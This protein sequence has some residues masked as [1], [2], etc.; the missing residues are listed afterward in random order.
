M[1]TVRILAASFSLTLL[2]GTASAATL[3][4]VTML[5]APVVR[6]SDLFDD[7]GRNAERVLG[8]A[9]TPGNQI[10][11]EAPQLAAIARQFGVEW[12]PASPADRAVL[13]RP[14]RLLPREAVFAAVKSVLMSAGASADCM[15]EMPGF[16]PPLTPADA[17]P[18]AVAT[19]LDYDAPSGRFA[20]ILSVTGTGMDPINLRI[21]GHV[22]DT[23]ELPVATTRLLA[24]AVLHAADV[25]MARVLVASVRGEVLHGMSEAIGMQLR[26]PVM[27]GEPLPVADVAHPTLVIRGA[28]VQMQLDTTGLSLLAQGIAQESGATGE[29]IR[30]LNPV[31]RAVLE[32]EVIGPGRVRI[33]PDSTPIAMLGPSGQIVSR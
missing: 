32:A 11:V 33:M 23:I 27:A 25:R 4:A 14:G 6:L 19:Q 30:V 17:D 26:H 20:A 7:A 2:S 5:H 18:H 1:T 3:R 21:A 22:D 15:V 13:E 29:R 10:V 28:I 16:T 12:R 31:S 24:G 8:T 9:P